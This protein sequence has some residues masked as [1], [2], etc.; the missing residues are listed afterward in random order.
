MNK[1]VTFQLIISLPVSFLIEVFSFPENSCRNTSKG[2]RKKSS[3][4]SAGKKQ[5]PMV[6][7]SDTSRTLPGWYSITYMLRL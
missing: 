2:K 3:E 1:L 7:G 4:P 6:D 5:L